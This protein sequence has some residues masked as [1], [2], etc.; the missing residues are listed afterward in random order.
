MQR[1]NEFIGTIFIPLLSSLIYCVR[2]WA[3]MTIFSACHILYINRTYY[4]SPKSCFQ[5]TW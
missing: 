2:I 5:I 1:N 3:I 4:I